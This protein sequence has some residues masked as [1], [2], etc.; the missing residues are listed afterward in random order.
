MS[1]G[2]SPYDKKSYKDSKRRR[3]QALKAERTGKIEPLSTAKR[4]AII[5]VCI[6]LAVA[7]SFGGW[8]VYSKYFKKSD[9]KS[10][11][12]QAEQFADEELLTIINRQNPLDSA[13]VPELADFQNVKVNVLLLDS[14][15]EM[16]DKAEEEGIELEVI[17]GYVSYD[18][19]DTLYNEKLSEFLANPDY[20]QVRAQAA[21]QK[22]VP[23]AGCSEAQTGLLIGF[24]VSD[25]QALAFIER[26]CVN[27]GFVQRYPQDKEDL[28]HIAHSKSL[29]RYVGKDNAIKMRSY[30]MCR[31]E[32][33]EYL[34]L[35]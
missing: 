19:Q 22:L 30:H 6:L 10:L 4:R 18:E 28:T 7:V 12:Q 21:A 33:S 14:L 17:S 35:Q 11:S 29:Y 1:Y 9:N 25:S 3:K 8:F 27:Y 32:Y 23:P 5:I 13:D 15:D 20:T 24:D 26:N 2:F 34:A 31:E 16:C